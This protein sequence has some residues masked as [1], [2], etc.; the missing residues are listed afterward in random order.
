MIHQIPALIPRVVAVGVL[1]ALVLT[2]PNAKSGT[3][4]AE[5][6]LNGNNQNDAAKDGSPRNST[7]D[8]CPATDGGDCIDRRRDGH[9]GIIRAG[10][11][12]FLLL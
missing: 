2:V 1:P 10:G 12:G 4:Q 5:Q 9:P 11:Q 3:E 8:M 6:K 7:M